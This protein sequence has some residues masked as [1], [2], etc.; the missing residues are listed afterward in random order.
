MFKVNN[1]NALERHILVFV[2]L[3][4]TIFRNF[5]SVS[6]VYFEQVQVT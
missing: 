5:S 3:T 6:I 4:F 2:L 1:K